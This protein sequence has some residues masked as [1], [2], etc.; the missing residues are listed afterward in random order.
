ME[1]LFFTAPK[2]A[3]P[4]IY[5]PAYHLLCLL[6]EPEGTPRDKICSEL[7]G[8][9]RS[10]LQ[11]LTG[12]Y[13]QHWLIHSEI[14]EFEGRNQAFYL[15]DTRHSSCDWEADKEARTIARKQYKDRSYKTSENAV[16]RLERARIEK[17]EADRE[18]Q[19][20]LETKKPSMS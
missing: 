5:C 17:A 6:V 2:G 3:I 8:G 16:K 14:R 12:E 4:D 1:D 18:Y 7:G 15:L 19:E 10:Y 20:M 9:F 13:Y 11:Q